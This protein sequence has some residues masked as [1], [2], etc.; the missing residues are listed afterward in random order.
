MNPEELAK[1]FHPFKQVGEH[2]NRTE[3]TGLG[4]AITRQ[5]VHLMKGIIQ[6]ES[7]PNQ[8]STFWFEIPVA[9][10]SCGMINDSIESE[11]DEIVGYKGKRRQILA[12]DDQLENRMV[13]LNLLSPLGFEM[14]LA[15]N[16][17]EG[18]E[19]AKTIQP[20]LILL[21]LVM[22]VM[23]GFEMIQKSR[24]ITAIKDVP[25]VVVSAC[26]MRIRRKVSIWAV[27]GLSPSRSTQ[28]NYSPSWLNV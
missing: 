15:E 25:I 18:L 23:T 17:E 2:K 5:L 26:S 19:K 4:L 9:I 14:S 13:L 1:I 12:I 27:K 10:A 6:V 3:G 8:G 11:S 24:Q 20:D 28:G 16:G 22:P 21:D 7:E